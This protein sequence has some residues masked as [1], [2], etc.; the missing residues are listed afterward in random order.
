M[1]VEAET[2]EAAETCERAPLL[3]REVERPRWTNPPRVG[4]IYS[5]EN[6]DQIEPLVNDL[7]YELTDQ[8]NFSPINIKTTQT[9][10]IIDIPLYV[11]HFHQRSDIVFAL[12]V[13]YRASPEYEQRLVDLF[14]E[15]IGAASPPGRL[16]V[17]DCVLVRDN[18][19]QLDAHINAMADVNSSMASMWARRAIDTYMMLSKPPI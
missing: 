19:K 7:R 10:S 16:P 5:S 15:R 12:G 18:Q 1:T 2:F 6:W 9:E 4:I 3:R 8:Y 11:N 17:F 14:T 13:V